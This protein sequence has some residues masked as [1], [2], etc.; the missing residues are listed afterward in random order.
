MHNAIQPLNLAI[1]R[2]KLCRDLR[3]VFVSCLIVSLFPEFALP[4]LSLFLPQAA[5]LFLML[6]PSVV[7]FL[8]REVVV[9]V[10]KLTRPTRSSPSQWSRRHILSL[11]QV[12]VSK[13][14]RYY[15]RIQRY[16]DTVYRHRDRQRDSHKDPV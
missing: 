6:V 2:L 3:I 9:E 5:F 1:M 11:Q 13:Q 16:R 15:I 10:T 8:A 12:R 14:Y 4:P 7:K